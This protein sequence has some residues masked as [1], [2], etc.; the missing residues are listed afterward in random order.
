MSSK[1]AVCRIDRNQARDLF[2]LRQ[3]HVLQNQDH[4]KYDLCSQADDV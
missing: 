3:R 2:D 1:E 4:S